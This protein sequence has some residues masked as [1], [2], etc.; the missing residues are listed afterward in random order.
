VENNAPGNLRRQ[1]DPPSHP[2]RSWLVGLLLLSGLILLVTHRGELEHFAELV[3]HAEPKWLIIAVALQV[4]TYFSVATVWYVALRQAG[5]HQKYLSLVPLGIAKLFSDQAMPSAGM[6]GTAFFVTALKRRG[7][8]TELCMATLLLS[9]I[10]YYGAYLLAALAS[11]LLLWLY[12]AIHAWIIGLSIVFGLVAAGIP[13]GALWLRRLGAREL[14][15][16]VRRI[17]GLENFLDAVANAPGELLKR[18]S[19]VLTCVLLHGSVFAL[20]AAT[21]WVMLHVVGLEVSFWTAFPSFVLASMVATIG[22]IPLGLGTFEVTCVSMLGVLGVPVEAA[23]TATLLLRGFT[24][25]VPMLPG[26][27]LARRALR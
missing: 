27:W 12:H 20:D 24:L 26:M 14:P 23:L 6:S 13:A 8:S 19:L 1:N 15:A 17:P 9:L 18:P 2:L 10:A 5:L 11:V 16:P 25:W 7:V 4:A 22:P 21:L 3:R